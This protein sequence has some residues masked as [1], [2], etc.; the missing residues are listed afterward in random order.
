MV[1][2]GSERQDFEKIATALHSS[3]ELQNRLLPKEFADCALIDHSRNG[4]FLAIIRQMIRDSHQ[5]RLMV[6]VGLP[7][8]N[9]S[10]SIDFLRLWGWRGILIESSPELHPAIQSR[11][12]G[13][14]FEL[15]EA[16]VLDRGAGRSRRRRRRCETSQP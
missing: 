4:E 3:P 11:F 15:V 8:P 2:G 16:N 5:P 13:L 7:F 1:Q 6:E 12:S 9:A 10:F 14:N